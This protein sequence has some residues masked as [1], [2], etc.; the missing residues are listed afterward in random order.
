MPSQPTKLHETLNR[1]KTCF[2]AYYGFNTLPGAAQD[3]TRVGTLIATAPLP[4][5]W[6]SSIGIRTTTFAG[7][8]DFTSIL[9]VLGQGA[10]TAALRQVE[11][12]M[13]G[14]EY[15]LAWGDIQA[16]SAELELRRV[17]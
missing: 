1:A 10:G 6:L 5:S 14:E 16:L 8:S 13:E 11:W 2:K 3:A 15:G 7:G 4:K 12:I 9:S 17:A